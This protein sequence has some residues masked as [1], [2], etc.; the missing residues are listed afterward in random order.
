MGVFGKKD[1]LQIIAFQTYGTDAHLY[2]RGRALEDEEIDLADKG[3]FKLIRNTYQRF[4]ADEIK[5]TPL[6]I[7]LVDGRAVSGETNDDGYYLIDLPS[8]DLSQLINDEGWLQYAIS[9]SDYS[10]KREILH[11]NRFPGEMMIP[12]EDAEFGIISDIDDTILWTG[13]ASFLKWRAILRTFFS[14]VGQRIPLKGA[15]KLYHRLHHGKSGKAVNPIFYVSNSPWNLYR[16][17]EF[18]LIKNSFPKGPILLRSL[19]AALTKNHDN[20][21]PH[22]QH[23]IRNILKT[24]PGLS[25]ILIGDSGEYDADIYKEIAEEYP[26][27]ILAIYL[28][29]VGH[30]KRMVRVKD[31]FA[32]FDSTPVLFVENSDQLELHAKQIGLL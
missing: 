11:E 1:K 20:D 4:D 6:N 5:H 16:Y 7:K 21:R 31:L 19:R 29:D 10:L 30:R 17:L 14:N 26:N 12:H 22:K 24:Y 3:F 2:L 23:E 9:Y 18:F 32:E 15:A 13:V 25:F 8:K 27:Q 28:R